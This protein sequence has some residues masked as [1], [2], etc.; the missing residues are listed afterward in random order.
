MG[1]EF[2]QQLVQT[3]AKVNLCLRLCGKRAD[4]YHLIDSVMVP[5]SLCDELLLAIRSPQRGALRPSVSVEADCAQIP[6]GTDNLAHRAA[7]AFVKVTQQS[8]A[9]DI[10]IRKR[11]PVGSGLGGGSSDAAAVLLALNR[12]LGYPLQPA[13]LANV[14]ASIGTD[15]P[16]FVCGRPARVTGVG[17]QIVPITLSATLNLVVCSDGYTLS[18]ADVYRQV[19][20]ASHSLTS[21]PPVS[22][23]TDF[24]EGRRPFSDLLV[25]DLEQAAAQIHPE[26][27]SLKARVMEEGAQ[28]ALMTGSGSAVFGVWADPHSAAQAAARLRGQGLWAEAVQTLEL[29]PALGN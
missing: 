4:G 12:L 24:V 16:F 15:V 23:I 8:I 28:A 26:V 25:N 9:V 18:T 13:R 5:I 14:G 22:N 17:E 1:I 2:R 6:A 21:D 10:Q 11:I 20:V 19:R 3:P 29:S 27:L 7:T